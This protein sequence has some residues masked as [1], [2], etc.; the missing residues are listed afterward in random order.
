[1]KFLVCVLALTAGCPAPDK[2]E[3]IE[4]P[5]EECYAPCLAWSLAEISISPD[6]APNPPKP[7][8]PTPEGECTNCNGTGKIDGDH[9]GTY[10]Y[11]C[12]VCGGDGVAQVSVVVEPLPLKEEPVPFR[13]PEIV[14]DIVAPPVTEHYMV[15]DEV[16]YVWDTD[17]FYADTGKKIVMS[18]GDPS[19]ETFVTMCK[20]DMCYKVNINTRTVLT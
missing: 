10:D 9:D 4:V 3:T 15:W 16:E 7:K 14:P 6:P 20:G 19:T 17:A 18:Y 13:K 5:A 2:V 1:M 12:G 11:D 8:P